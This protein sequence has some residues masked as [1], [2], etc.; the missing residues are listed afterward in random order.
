MTT[1][2]PD[3]TGAWGLLSAPR[4]DRVDGQN[5]WATPTVNSARR[6]G[7]DG[8][9]HGSIGLLESTVHDPSVGL[10]FGCVR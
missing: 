7:L 4:C 9:T 10:G 6:T 3:P 5:G 8:G 1:P 2:G